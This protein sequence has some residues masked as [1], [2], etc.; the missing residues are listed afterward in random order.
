MKNKNLFSFVMSTVVFV[1][2]LLALVGWTF[3]LRSLVSLHPSWVTMKIWTAVGIMLA[4]IA[5][6]CS[7]AY[8]KT[9]NIDWCGRAFGAKSL[10]AILQVSII[11]AA[12]LK[13][14]FS[15]TN[16]FLIAGYE[17]QSGWK[18]SMPSFI[19]VLV[20]TI[21]AFGV[22]RFPYA[23][24]TFMIAIGFSTVLGYMTNTPELYYSWYGKVSPVAFNTGI[25]FLLLSF[26]I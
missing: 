19:T 6:F 26:G 18:N 14:I 3:N 25:C 10:L 1:I 22:N 9:E 17:L 4:S 12:F 15:G 5:V 2:A 8:R 20:L 16:V 13:Y 24:K 7:A 21:F 11:I 23:V